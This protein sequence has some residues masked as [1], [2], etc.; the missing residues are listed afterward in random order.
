MK[1]LAVPDVVRERRRCWR[2]RSAYAIGQTSRVPRHTKQPCYDWW[3]WIVDAI[4][5][6]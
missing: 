1:A 4:V 3:S 2:P 5:R 6:R